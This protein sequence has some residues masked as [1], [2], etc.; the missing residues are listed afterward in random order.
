MLV[1]TG[2]S[3]KPLEA[4]IKRQQDASAYALLSTTR[5]CYANNNLPVLSS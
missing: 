2:N 1:Y 5:N 3:I 4:R